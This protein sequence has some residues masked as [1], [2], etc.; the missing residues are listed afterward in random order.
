MCGSE[1]SRYFWCVDL[2]LVNMV[3]ADVVIVGWTHHGNGLKEAPS[4]DKHAQVGRDK[5][6]RQN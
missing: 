3:D 5:D 6:E 1:Q 2:V 4:Q